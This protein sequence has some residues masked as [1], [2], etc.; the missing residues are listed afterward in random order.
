MAD[1]TAGEVHVAAGVICNES[2]LVL[3]AQRQPGRHLA[4]G[5]EFP[6][7]KVAPG[8]TVLQAL[9][10]EL[11]EEIGIDVLEAAP[12]MAYRHAYPE[13]VVLLD[14]WR[15]R[16]YAGQPRPLEGQPLRWEAVNRLLESG[17]LAADQPVVKALLAAEGKPSDSR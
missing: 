5:W 2:G 4:G 3:I 8:E 7:G 1:A 17:L 14:V 9:T 12:L 6:G 13:R 15:V 16:R 10:R 11:R